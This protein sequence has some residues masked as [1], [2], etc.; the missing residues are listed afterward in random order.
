MTS[1]G[2]AIVVGCVCM[3]CV[4]SEAP[5]VQTIE[6]PIV[7]G[8]VSPPSD[9][10]VVNILSPAQICT[11][12]LIAPNLVLTA[13]HCVTPRETNVANCTFQGEPVGDDAK[14]VGEYPASQLEIRIGVE[15]T[16]TPAAYGKALV[17]FDNDTFCSS[18]IALIVLD[19]PLDSV[20]Y[21][22]V[23]LTRPV[24]VGELM[25]I[26]GYG[27]A[28]TN[29][30]LSSGGAIQRRRRSHLE[31]NDV[32]RTRF[33]PVGGEAP[34]GRFILGTGICNGDTGGPAIVEATGAVAGV[35][36]MLGTSD[37]ANSDVNEYVLLAEYFDLMQQGFEQA[38]H[39]VWLENEAAPAQKP[40]MQSHG[41]ALSV[42]SAGARDVRVEATGCWFLSLGLRR[43]RRRRLTRRPPRARSVGGH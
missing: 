27:D 8:E 28:P 40:T 43:Y 22:P 39:P 29:G 16:A 19:R 17:S 5:L 13:R 38:G 33:D 18:D 23:R 37:C 4:V 7:N 26:I 34:K 11:G 21:L 31:V 14:V 25:T 12:T 30:Q 6:E 32:G 1:T 42:S 3:G 41:C 15:Y 20:P 35:A 2:W 10:A 24:Y 36:S 9:D